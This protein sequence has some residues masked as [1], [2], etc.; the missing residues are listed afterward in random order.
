[1]DDMQ[2]DLP[3]Q[4]LEREDAQQARQA[5][6]VPERQNS[7]DAAANEAAGWSNWSYRLTAD[8][9]RGGVRLKD[10]IYGYK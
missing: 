9:W 1:M 6:Q 8:S 4:A 5:E 3:V 2:S 10:V 7:W